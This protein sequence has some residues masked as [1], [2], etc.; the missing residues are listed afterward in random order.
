MQG[1]ASVGI[2]QYI[3]SPT[4]TLKSRNWGEFL[5]G[6]SSKRNPTQTL[7]SERYELARVFEAD[8]LNI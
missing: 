5:S 1:E 3:L 2:I 4:G 8:D 6:T 7:K